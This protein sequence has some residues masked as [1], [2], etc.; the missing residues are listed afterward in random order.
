MKQKQ[1]GNW[2]NVEYSVMNLN[3]NSGRGLN[4][5]KKFK[6]DKQTSIFLWGKAKPPRLFPQHADQASPFRHEQ[7]STKRFIAITAAKDGSHAFGVTDNDWSFVWG[8]CDFPGALGLGRDTK[9]T[10][11]YLLKPLKKKQ[12]KEIACSSAHGVAITETGQ[13]F[14]WGQAML[15]GL[16]SDTSEPSPLN[17]LANLGIF[18]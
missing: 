3:A 1:K 16:P 6:A 7:L 5:R 17:F 13:V 9:S 14:G 18:F 10:L 2:D 4:F 12:V 8:E 11:P 15:T